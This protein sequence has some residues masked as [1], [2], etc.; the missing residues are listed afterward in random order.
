M[1]LIIL[2]ITKM[3]LFNI[4]HVTQ[5]L[6][7]S[8]LLGSL[9]SAAPFYNGIY[10]PSN[11]NYQSNNNTI[12]QTNLNVL[13]S[14]LL[15][16]ATQGSPSYTTSMGLGTANSANGNYL[17]RG[18][19]S[20]ITC[21][22]CVTAAVANI[23]NLCPNKTE[24]IIWYDECMVRYTRS[25]FSPLSIV[26]RLNLW[27]HKNIST[28]DLDNFNE[29]LLTFLG[30]LAS[31]AA[32]SQTA[33]K[34]S[35]GEENFTVK[36]SQQIRLYGLAQCMPGMTTH[37]CEG[38][39]VNASRT[40][41]TCCE[42][43]QGARALL[44]WC[45]IRYDS[46]RFYNTTGTS[47]SLPPLLSPPP[48]SGKKKSE[49]GKIAVI[50]VIVVV[51]IILFCL[52][53]YFILRRRTRK[54]YKTLLKENY[55]LDDLLSYAWSQWRDQTPL[56]ILDKNIKESCDHSEVIKCIQVGLLC[57]QNKPDDRPTMAKVVSYFS[58]P[59]V[60]L[61]FPADPNNYMH[62]QILQKMVAGE[63]SS[64]ST[65]VNELTIPR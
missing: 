51:P 26:P 28:L 60:E 12:F 22:D 47:A 56:E 11:V 50:V 65:E 39:L 30:G 3:F 4:N 63:S 44:A 57:V 25:Y 41:P 19:V 23:T 8:L 54:R 16:N 15:S 48:S 18:D 17:C 27:V 45:N 49:A 52:G 53:C 34:F 33:M 21:R 6:L 20:S 61:P 38:C 58:S 10:C 29:W 43:R 24:S 46:Y 31:Q 35:T 36:S 14:S 55:D 9:T 37:E 40:L 7:F 2:M 13:L 1:S 32:N 42:G 59:E 5:F 62:N 64:R